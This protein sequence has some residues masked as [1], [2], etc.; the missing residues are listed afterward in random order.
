MRGKFILVSNPE[1]SFV[2]YFPLD[3]RIELHD[4]NQDYRSGNSTTVPKKYRV[5]SREE[6]QADLD[7][8]LAFWNSHFQ[9]TVYEEED[10]DEEGKEVEEGKDGMEAGEE[11]D[12]GKEL[13]K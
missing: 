4:L 7:V 6:T 3:S 9:E 5:A 10:D 1:S 11:M 13:Q 8:G 12:L 2:G